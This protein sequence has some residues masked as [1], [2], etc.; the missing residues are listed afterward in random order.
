MFKDMGMYK[1]EK[2]EEKEDQDLFQGIKCESSFYSFS[3]D[4]RFRILC[5][6]MIKHP[7]WD[8]TV[9]ILIALSSFKL[10][11]DTY[12]MEIEEQT[13]IIVVS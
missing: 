6:K 11:F 3:K 13:P 5:Y 10:G 7:L 2:K 9:L 4:N 12:F 8:Q 1:K